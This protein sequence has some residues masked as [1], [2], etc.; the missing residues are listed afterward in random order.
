[1]LRLL[2]T[3]LLV[4]ALFL[5]PLATTSSIL[6][7]PSNQGVAAA[8][9]VYRDLTPQKIKPEVLGL[10]L[11]VKAAAVLDVQSGA[12]LYT[13]NANAELN[14]AS[15]TKLMT[16]LVW[17]DE[18]VPVD[19]IVEIKASDARPGGVAYVL[20]KEQYRVQELL[21]ASLI[22]SANDA[23]VALARSTGLT[24]EEFVAK[25]NA[26]AKDLGLAK[27]HFA[28]VTGLSVENVSTAQEASILALAAF[29]RP[30]IAAY[31]AKSE[32]QLVDLAGQQKA[33]IHTAKKLMSK[34]QLSPLQLGLLAGK[35]GHISE[36]GYNFIG[37]FN[38][39]Q[40]QILVTIIGAP[41]EDSR[42][43]QAEQLAYWV[44]EN[45]QWP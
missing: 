28:D 27:T 42:L 8:R 35:T 30:E 34:D 38:R 44:F 4:S 40:R 13:D 45:Y 16:A 21:A 20:A 10:R 6:S 31:S 9:T 33:L 12:F 43:R 36:V 41:D 26:K 11:P 18:K 23:T 37:L 14:L 1:M 7:W 2:L 5:P 19:K 29:K 3:N 17:L 22:A 39:Q 15:L 32:Y 24:E 25:M